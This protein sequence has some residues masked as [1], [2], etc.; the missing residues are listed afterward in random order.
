MLSTP[1]TVSPIP[2]IIGV[3]IVLALMIYYSV[4]TSAVPVNPSVAA[5]ETPKPSGSQSARGT[6][7]VMVS[8]DGCPRDDN[9]IINLEP[10]DQVQVL[11]SYEPTDPAYKVLPPD[12]PLS[13]KMYL[14]YVKVLSGPHANEFC[15]ASTADVGGAR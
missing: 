11:S 10:G 4:S 14:S 12:S 3:L 13:K 6:A 8:S 9:Q 1:K 15:W 5:T 7:R 2:A